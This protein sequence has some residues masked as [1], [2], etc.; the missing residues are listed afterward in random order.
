MVNAPQIEVCPPKLLTIPGVLLIYVYG[1]LLFIPFLVSVVAISSL[2]LGSMTWLIL[3]ALAALT[4][5]MLPFAQGNARVVR[6]VRT[7]NAFPG[8][9]EGCFLRGGRTD[10]C[11]G[12]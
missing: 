11:G 10:S 1:L 7:L 3:I 9:R 4:L 2:K 5:Y 8:K 6:M 12:A